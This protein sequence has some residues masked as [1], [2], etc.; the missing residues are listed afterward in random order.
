ME[1]TSRPDIIQV[2]VRILHLK[3]GSRISQ[4]V[5]M[6]GIRQHNSKPGRSLSRA[7]LHP[8]DIDARSRET[9]S[10]HLSQ[11]IAPDFRDEA[12]LRAKSAQVVREDRRRA[13]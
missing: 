11:R 10:G 1:V 3:H 8:A 12:D 6:L 7:L 2:D 9:F 5:S 13:S 4:H